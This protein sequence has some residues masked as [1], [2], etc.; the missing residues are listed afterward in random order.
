MDQALPQ[1]LAQTAELRRSILDGDFRA[2]LTW[3]LGPLGASA[4]PVTGASL[5]R[6][7]R[8]AECTCPEFCER[9]HENE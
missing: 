8:S 1:P 6:W 7:A 9:D 3:A 2:A 4:N 5:A